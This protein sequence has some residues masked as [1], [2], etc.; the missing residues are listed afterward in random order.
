MNSE[1]DIVMDLAGIY[2]D[3]TAAY[4]T[5][6]FIKEHLK[7]C[8]NCRKFYKQFSGL[9]RKNK[10]SETSEIPKWEGNYDEIARRIRKRRLISSLIGITYSVSMLCIIASLMKRTR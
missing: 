3:K 4:E 10:L 2:F 5:N 7:T 9:K 1:C 8:E 6:E